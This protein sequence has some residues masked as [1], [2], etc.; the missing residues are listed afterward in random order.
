MQRC[1][2]Q[3]GY[4]KPSKTLQNSS[5]RGGPWN[6]PLKPNMR[7]YKTIVQPLPPLTIVHL[8]AL[9]PY[10]LALLPMMVPESFILYSKSP[11]ITIPLEQEGGCLHTKPLVILLALEAG[12]ICDHPAARKMRKMT[13]DSPQ[14]VLHPP[15]DPNQFVSRIPSLEH[16]CVGYRYLTPTP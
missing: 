13:A 14:T 5:H 9:P 2:H 4:P 1:V 3:K 11:C 8:S 12:I 7:C 15:H 10:A 6:P 16:T